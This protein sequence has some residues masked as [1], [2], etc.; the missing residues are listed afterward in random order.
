M[1]EQLCSRCH[2]RPATANRYCTICNAE[3]MRKSRQDNIPRT[4]TLALADSLGV[5]VDPG[6]AVFVDGL[7]D[8]QA[9]FLLEH[10]YGK[11]VAQ[12]KLH[13]LMEDGRLE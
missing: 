9:L 13:L 8:A 5:T 10:M 4:D 3:R 7:T 1:T 12:R 6:I 11:E 2:E